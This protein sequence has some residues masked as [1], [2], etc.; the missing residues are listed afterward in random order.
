MY[1]S[2]LDHDLL[3]REEEDDD[4]GRKGVNKNGMIGLH[5]QT[6]K[7]TMSS[8]SGNGITFCWI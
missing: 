5:K 3:E 4:N 1:G 2:R 8:C 6:H 7:K